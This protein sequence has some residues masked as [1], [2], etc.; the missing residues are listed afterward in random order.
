MSKRTDL[1]APCVVYCGR[2]TPTS[3]SQRVPQ[4]ESPRTARKLKPANQHNVPLGLT[5]SIHCRQVVANFRRHHPKA[6]KLIC[7][8]INQTSIKEQQERDIDQNHWATVARPSH[9][10]SRKPCRPAVV[11]LRVLIT[12]LKI[13]HGPCDGILFDS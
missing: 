5:L 13:F 2:A 4:S 7:V 10:I 9:R 11:L 1:A 3:Q 8:L 6:S 12:F